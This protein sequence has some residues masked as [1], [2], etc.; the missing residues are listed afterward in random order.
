LYEI[1]IK[2]PFRYAILSPVQGGG[3]HYTKQF[4]CDHWNNQQIGWI[5]KQVKDN[6]RYSNSN[7]KNNNSNNNSNSNSDI[8][9]NIRRETLAILE[10]HLF[11]ASLILFTQRH[12]DIPIPI[13]IGYQK[14]VSSQKRFSNAFIDTLR[15]IPSDEIV[16]FGKKLHD[17]VIL[18]MKSS[19]PFS[20]SSTSHSSL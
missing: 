6:I 19:S 17:H 1:H 18:E 12:F 4:P 8:V 13:W 7:N 2:N 14:L 5:K 15:Q 9:S 10:N 3:N 20:F 11:L 16:R